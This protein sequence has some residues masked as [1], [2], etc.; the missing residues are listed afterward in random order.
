L[1]RSISWPQTW[2]GWDSSTRPNARS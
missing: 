2:E 1:T